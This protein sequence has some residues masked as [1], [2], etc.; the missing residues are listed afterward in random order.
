MKKKILL[1]F[2]ALIIATLVTTCSMSSPPTHIHPVTPFELARY[3]GKWYE[4][5]RLDNRFEKGLDFVTALYQTQADGSVRV[6]NKGFNLAKKRW[7]QS[8]GKAKF[9]GNSN[10]AALKVSFFGPFYASYTVFVLDKNYQYAVV[11]GPNRD[12]LWIL[13]RTPTLTHPIKQQLV[14]LAKKQGFATSDLRWT[15]Q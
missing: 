12:Y 15:R 9:I 14:M 10:T 13:A 8:I 1:P 7:Q 4:I 2:A 3:Q 11:C 5:A 6:V